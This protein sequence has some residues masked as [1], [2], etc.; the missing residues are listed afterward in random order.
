MRIGA[1][2]VGLWM[3]PDSAGVHGRCPLEMRIFTGIIVGI[4]R[5][6][7]PSG[8]SARLFGRLAPA[9]HRAGGA[10]LHSRPQRAAWI[11]LLG[12]ACLLFLAGI[13]GAALQLAVPAGRSGLNPKKERLVG[14]LSLARDHA[15]S[16][17]CAKSEF[18]AN[19]SHE[20]RTPMNAIIGFSEL[21]MMD[22]DCSEELQLD[23]SK[24]FTARRVGCSGFSTTSSI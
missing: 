8:G 10:G 24:R 11:L 18:L 12:L 21:A 2:R 13:Y 4:G 7:V 14:E 9:F 3:G 23:I 5:G 1:H 17:N 22:A 20:I 15:E 16:A 19:M 6:S